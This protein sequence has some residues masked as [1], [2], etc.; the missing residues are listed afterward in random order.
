LGIKVEG[1]NRDERQRALSCDAD[2]TRARNVGIGHLEDIS[3]GGKR[4]RLAESPSRKG[5]EGEQRQ[6][7]SEPRRRNLCKRKLL[8]GGVLTERLAKKGK[9]GLLGKEHPH[10]PEIAQSQGGGGAIVDPEHYRY[11]SAK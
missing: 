9:E 2:V 6:E 3:R 8:A 11:L 5:K 1:E 10:S 4:G 7:Y